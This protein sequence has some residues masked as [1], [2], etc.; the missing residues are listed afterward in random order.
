M[1]P[2]ER[3]GRQIN[4]FT[5]SEDTQTIHSTNSGEPGE[6]EDEAPLCSHG[7]GSDV[8]TGCHDFWTHNGCSINNFYCKTYAM[9]EDNR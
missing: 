7:D 5:Q 3:N 1:Q 2:V 6:D 9:D 4:T 8:S